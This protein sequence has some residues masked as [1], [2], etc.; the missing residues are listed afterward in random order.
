MRA[1][2]VKPSCC[3]RG[4]REVPRHALDERPAVD[5]RHDDA[6]PAIGDLHERAARQRLVGDADELLGHLLAAGRRVAVQAGA[7]PG[8]HGGL[9]DP[10][11]DLGRGVGDRRGA[12]A[13]E[14]RADPLLAEHLRAPAHAEAA[15][16]ADRGPGLRAPGLGGLVVALHPQ[17]AAAGAARDGAGQRGLAAEQRLRR[18]DERDVGGRLRLRRARAAGRLRGRGRGQREC[19]GQEGR[20]KPDRGNE[21][22]RCFLRCL[23]GELTGSRRESSATDDWSRPIRP[24][25]PPGSH[26]VPRSPW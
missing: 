11:G 10:H 23:R 1:V 17:H 2:S 9:E 4:R 7:V 8:R 21:P 5:D 19:D 26:W 16:A 20:R 13:L 25:D 14:R 12:A 24:R 22:H 15:L 18:G 3:G 6:G